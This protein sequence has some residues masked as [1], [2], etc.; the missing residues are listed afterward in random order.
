VSAWTEAGCRPRRKTLVAALAAVLSLL[1]CAPATLV[2]YRPQDAPTV[3]LPLALAGV[4]DERAAFA[5]LFQAQLAVTAQ[6]GGASI[7]EWLH[8]VPA[9][10]ALPSAPGVMTQARFAAMAPGTSVLLVPGL[11]GDCVGA[12]S[13]PFG[14]GVVRSV[15]RSPREAYRQYDDL[16]LGSIRLVALPGRASSEANGVLLADAIRAEA[17]RPGVERIVLVVYSKGLADALHA[18]DRLERDGGLPPSIVALVSVAGPVM[19]TPLA[20]WFEGAYET[21]SP[22]VNPLDCTPAQGG[23]LASLTRRERL[24]W[25]LAHPLPAGI[26]RFSIVAHTVAEETAPPL[27]IPAAWLAAIDPRNDGQLIASDAILPGSTLLAEARADH[28]DVALPR[29]RDPNAFMR[30]MASGR[31]YPREALFR[32]MLIWVVGGGP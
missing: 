10:A 16:G 13:V 31:D 11:F 28:W 2:P 5:A 19:G 6:G 24:A 21:V 25:L 29:N 14:D 23:D 27:R 4:R 26:A 15:E 18:L 3:T 7:G 32:A 22:W 8:G 1:G 17:A 12:Q 9:A 20:D 30:S